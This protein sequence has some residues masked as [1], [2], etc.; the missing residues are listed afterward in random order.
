M[1][2]S[3]SERQPNQM[4]GCWA[5][6]KENIWVTTNISI[7]NHLFKKIHDKKKKKAHEITMVKSSGP[8]QNEYRIQRTESLIDTDKRPELTP[9]GGSKWAAQ[10]PPKQ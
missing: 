2:R 10:P 8:E 3:I 7:F 4:L 6:P 5:S 1:V 9:N